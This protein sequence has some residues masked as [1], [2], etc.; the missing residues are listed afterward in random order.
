MGI[1]RRFNKS[2][3]INQVCHPLRSPDVNIVVTGSSIDFF[4]NKKSIIVACCQRLADLEKE[5]SNRQDYTLAWCDMKADKRDEHTKKLVRKLSDH[6]K[7]FTDIMECYQYL[8]DKRD[9]IFLIIS[10][11]CASQCLPRIHDLPAV[12]S[13][14]IYCAS[15]SKY[16]SLIDTNKKV[17]S[18]ISTERELLN[19][20]HW[21]TE[22]KCSTQL[23][24]CGNDLRRLTRDSSLF[25]AYLLVLDGIPHGSTKEDMIRVCRA[26][27]AGN[28]TENSN[29]DEFEA[30]YTQDQ[31]VTWYTRSSFVYKMLKKVLRLF[32]LNKLY[33]FGF[34]IRDLQ[35][36]LEKWHRVPSKA[37]SVYRG[38]TMSLVNIAQLQA[39]VGNL[40]APNGFLSTSRNSDIA[41]KYA[42]KQGILEQDDKFCNV[43][44]EIEINTDVS[45]SCIFADIA[46]VSAFAEEREI[47]FS[48][49]TV[50]RVNEVTLSPETSI[51]TVKMKAANNKEYSLVE[52]LLAIARDKF[53]EHAN[54]QL[55]LKLL[56]HAQSYSHHHFNF[57]LSWTWT[58]IKNGMHATSQRA[59]K[60]LVSGAY[61]FTRANYLHSI[62]TRTAVESTGKKGHK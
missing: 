45:L 40:V 61:R 17:V 21:W 14:F 34:Y 29:I 51:Y 55:I 33:A 31:A 42:K 4:E 49:G 7:V 47:L 8:S 6:V 10:G 3:F 35:K 44:L 22:L 23:Y 57:D 25:L 48:I 1:D 60:A 54:Q 32:D 36:Q 28:I 62:T 9:P 58:D 53:E 59:V 12:D 19:Q 15:P 18:C 39:N 20:V 56:H 5:S 16:K 52:N 38:L 46:H 43:L 2:F 13:I 24:T 50:F 37:F 30:N 27:Y 41:M 11:S 26:Y